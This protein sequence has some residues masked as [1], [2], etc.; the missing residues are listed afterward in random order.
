MVFHVSDYKIHQ[1]LYC[2]FYYSRT[3]VYSRCTIFDFDNLRFAEIFI[4]FGFY[5]RLSLSIFS[6]SPCKLKLGFK[7]FNT[8]FVSDDI[9]IFTVGHLLNQSMAI[10]I[11]CSPFSFCGSYFRKN[12]FEV[13]VPVVLLLF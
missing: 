5:P 10:S 2:A 11:W 7:K 4:F 3:G 8:S 9:Q 13:F 1:R 6:G 12:L